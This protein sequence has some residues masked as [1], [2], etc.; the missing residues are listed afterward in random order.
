[1]VVHNKFIEVLETR[2][3]CKEGHCVRI[4]LRY[5]NVTKVEW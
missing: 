3:A 5:C 2:T 4:S 1:M